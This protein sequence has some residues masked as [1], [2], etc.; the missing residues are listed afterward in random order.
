MNTLTKL[1]KFV[2]YLKRTKLPVRRV[3]IGTIEVSG[4]WGEGLEAT[5]AYEAMLSQLVEAIS[6]LDDGQL[7]ATQWETEDEPERSMRVELWG[8]L[9]GIP[10]RLGFPMAAINSRDAAA[11]QYLRTNAPGLAE[12]E[13]NTWLPVPLDVMQATAREAEAVSE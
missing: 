2:T 3:G 13:N 6:T 9:A 4:K 7:V 11:M 5:L 8:T 10:V 1:Q 12:V